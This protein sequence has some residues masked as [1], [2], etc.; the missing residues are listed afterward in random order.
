M[1]TLI[2]IPAYKEGKQIFKVI[3]DIK[4]KVKISFEVLVIDDGSG[5]NTGF[6]AKRAGAKVLRHSIN[7]GQGASLKTGV[8]FAID[9]PNY[10]KVVFFDADGQMSAEEIPLLCQA[11]DDG[12]DVALGSRF[13]G[14]VIDM[15]PIKRLTLKLALIFTRLTSGL[16]LTDTHNGFQAWK[17]EALKKINLTQDRMAYASQIINEVSRCQLKFKEVPVT[18]R[19]TEYSKAKGQ[20]IGNSIKILWDLFI[21]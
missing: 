21:K 13:L 8:S 19:Y 20:S 10:D 11:L 14:R 1:T 3:S 15:P 2:L 17:V 16:R 4:T 5:D 12:Y 9:H 7:R 18:I 6:E